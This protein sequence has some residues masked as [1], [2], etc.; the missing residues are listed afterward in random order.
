MRKVA[1]FLFLLVGSALVL[2]GTTADE[3]PLAP[4][5]G[6][7][8]T[9]GVS[10]DF[11]GASAPLTG[12]SAAD[13][14]RERI[15]LHSDP[16]E[17]AGGV[18]IQVRTVDASGNSLAAARVV[19][20]DGRLEQKASAM[21]R[22]QP[23]YKEPHTLPDRLADYGF[24][25]TSDDHGSFVIEARG[26]V[27][28]L[29]GEWQH[30]AGTLR[31]DLSKPVSRE[32]LLVLAPGDTLGVHVVD[33]QGRPLVGVPMAAWFCNSDGLLGGGCGSDRYAPLGTT[34]QSGRVT[35][36]GWLD[37]VA[38]VRSLQGDHQLCAWVAPL[39]VG[40]SASTFVRVPECPADPIEIQITEPETIRCAIT[41]ANGHPLPWSK[42]T[43][44][45]RWPGQPWQFSPMRADDG[46][47]EFAFL[48]GGNWEYSVRYGSDVLGDGSFFVK[49]GE[50][51]LAC[52]NV[53][54]LVG[55]AGA[56]PDANLA[57]EFLSPMRGR[58]RLPVP[59][60]A[61]GSFHVPIYHKELL[62]LQA[63]GNRRRLCF[64]SGELTC[65][66]T[67][68]GTESIID[69]GMLEW[70]L[71]RFATL[72]VVDDRG[73]PV[74]DVTLY[75]AGLDGAQLRMN[76]NAR[77]AGSFDVSGSA[78]TPGIRVTCD[79]KGFVRTVV[80]VAPGE[81]RSV[82]MRRVLRLAARLDLLHGVD[83][84]VVWLRLRER[85]D[86]A[87][88]SW[89]PHESWQRAERAGE[90][91][92]VVRP[93][94]GIGRYRYELYSMRPAVLGGRGEV[95]FEAPEVPALDGTELRPVA[96]ELRLPPG[97][98]AC[99]VMAAG[100][101]GPKRPIRIC[102]VSAGNHSLA[103]TAAE[104]AL[105][106]CA[107]GLVPVSRSAAP[108]AI[109]VQMHELRSSAIPGLDMRTGVARLVPI[110]IKMSDNLDA[111]LPHQNEVGRKFQ[112]FGDWVKSNGQP[113]LPCNYRVLAGSNTFE[114]VFCGDHWVQRR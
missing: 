15:A 110:S 50:A 60:E 65:W 46:R 55:T 103:V 8:G 49:A 104:E 63:Q 79:A 93:E 91:T 13:A 98:E 34:D 39:L 80:E 35:F 83:P 52:N 19:W 68:T 74:E 7:N 75:C 96:L 102:R 58:I 10:A 81:T 43:L 5:L 95:D 88:A 84:D 105:W 22:V 30:L 27:V 11:D 23:R 108:N 71:P 90:R 86:A 56:M 113:L 20:A 99:W 44:E 78:E 32:Y 64:R 33:R 2:Y 66:V 38:S 41:S 25:T 40:V 28:I 53:F 57:V 36:R 26:P 17:A 24:T 69:V 14:E 76:T 72:H 21:R 101:A 94:V 59:L 109:S 62:A 48:D 106:F 97:H 16:A 4:S 31:L 73:E 77:G 54:D 29:H 92:I 100:A 70:S 89:V 111:F 47:A 3:A 37:T 112:R 61:D 42:V 12:S 6:S 114:V 18:E 87:S 107:P 1:G 45:V 51:V 9:V 82:V 85:W 67:P